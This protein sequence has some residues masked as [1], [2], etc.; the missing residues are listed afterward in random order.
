MWGFANMLITAV[1]SARDRVRLV[2]L[3]RPTLR[4][5]THWTYLTRPVNVYST[6]ILEKGDFVSHFL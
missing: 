3:N 2:S 6:L 1:Q 5:H 4:G